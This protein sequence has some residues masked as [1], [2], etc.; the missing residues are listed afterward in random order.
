MKGIWLF[1]TSI[2]VMCSLELV[3]QS[4]WLLSVL[5]IAITGTGWSFVRWIKV[6]LF[7][8]IFSGP[9][10]IVQW[11]L[12][13]G[14]DT[15]GSILGTELTREAFQLS[16]V[17]TM[18]A[19]TLSFSSILFASTT[20]SRDVITVLVH[21]LRVPQRFAYA[22]ALALRFMPLLVDEARRIRAAQQ[23]RQLTPSAN[24]YI[25]IDRR[26]NYLIAV[27]NS[28]ANRIR[29][30]V[31]AMEGKQFDGATTRTVWRKLDFSCRA[32]TMAT[33]TV[34]AMIVTIIFG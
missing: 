8:F 13:P 10:F 17:L 19:L 26:Y 11:F 9:L 32:I 14:T 34:V 33:L 30:I 18:R 29:Y 21:Y 31:M 5:I 27:A 7:L 23:R 24:V 20:A 2:S 1:S 22:V 15:I 6:V 25:W 3:W 12:L 16:L 28:M 4:S